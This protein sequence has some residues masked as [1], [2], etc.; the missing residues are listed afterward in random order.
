MLE[1][2]PAI[3][4]AESELSERF[5]RSPGPG[6][7]NVNKVETAVQLRFDAA[8]SPSLPEDVRQRLLRLAGR[9]ADGEGVVTIEAHRFRTRE[10]NREDARMRLAELIRQAAH[11]P[12]PRIATRP[13]RASKERRLESKRAQSIV[14]RRRT[15][16]PRED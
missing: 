2:T 10:R 6:G 8:R 5:I 7:Q 11:R 12:K 14:K 9:R 13:S 15:E 4:I 1:I 16:R 3:L